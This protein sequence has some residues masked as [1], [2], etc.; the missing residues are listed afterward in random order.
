[1]KKKILSLLTIITMMI[2]I[3]NSSINSEVKAATGIGY[4]TIDSDPITQ[5]G[6]DAYI[7]YEFSVDVDNSPIGMVYVTFAWDPSKMTFDQAGSTRDNMAFANVDVTGGTAH[8]YLLDGTR[9]EKCGVTMKFTNVQETSAVNYQFRN[10]VPPA[11]AAAG[12]VEFAGYDL[13][14]LTTA[15]IQETGVS[16]IVL[17]LPPVS[18]AINQSNVTVVK[19]ESH[20]FNATVTNATDQTVTWSV[21][22]TDSTIDASGLLVVGANETTNTLTVT[23]TSN[24]DSTKIANTT[25]TVV[26]QPEVEVT[27]DSLTGEVEQG[28]SKTFAAT[29]TNATDQTVTWVVTGATS[30]DTTIDVN[31][32][33]TVGADEVAG[34]ILT[35][36][37][38][39]NEDTTKEATATILVTEKDSTEPTDPTDQTNP[40]TPTEPDTN[41]GESNPKTN[42]STNIVIFISLMSL[43]LIAFTVLATKRKQLIK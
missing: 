7:S 32:V 5:I 10:N 6:G 16:Q 41:N 22:G 31:G 27:I 42:D 14:E 28:A 39:S 1:M 29:V 20:Q 9:N 3:V 33:L 38:T 4:V 18:V 17:N 36:T 13:V 11:I 34:T 24:E 12:G 37:A 26:N 25:V 2:G 40:V 30:T 15:Q 23:A 43:F 19:G 8:A 35:I 21:D